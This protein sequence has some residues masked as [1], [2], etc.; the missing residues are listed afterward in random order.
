MISKW[1][2]F[3]FM[4][5]FDE[6]RVIYHIGGFRNMTLEFVVTVHRVMGRGSDLLRGKTS[7]VKVVVRVRRPE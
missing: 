3:F 6:G 1:S 2:S 5:I 7:R 4:G